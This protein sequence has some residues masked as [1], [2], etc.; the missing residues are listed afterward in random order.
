MT[1]F[2]M[3]PLV[4]N[5]Q[6]VRLQMSSGSFT[7]IS[8]EPLNTAPSSITTRGALMSPVHLRAL[9]LIATREPASMLPLAS[10]LMVSSSARMSA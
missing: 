7:S 6:N 9:L 10:P 8:I 5:L 2:A 4:S 3:C 1:V